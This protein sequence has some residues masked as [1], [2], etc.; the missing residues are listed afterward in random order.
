MQKT[1]KVK[2][3]ISYIDNLDLTED[4]KERLLSELEMLLTTD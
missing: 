4:E 3:A 1:Q 2:E